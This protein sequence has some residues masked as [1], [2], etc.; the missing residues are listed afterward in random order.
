MVM[1]RVHYNYTDYTNDIFQAWMFEGVEDSV[2]I[3][4]GNDREAHQ[5]A[6]QHGSPESGAGIAHFVNN[7]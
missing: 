4:G 3:F 7:N 1:F 5:Q 6:Q 2:E